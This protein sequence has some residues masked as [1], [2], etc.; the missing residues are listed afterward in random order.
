MSHGPLE[1]WP[2]THRLKY[3]SLEPLEPLHTAFSMR[4]A[5]SLQF[6]H[7]LPVMQTLARCLPSHVL[8]GDVGSAMIRTPAMFHRGTPNVGNVVR[9]QVT[10]VIK[11]R[12]GSRRAKCE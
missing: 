8:V 4:L 5:G 3:R 10:I 2:Q 7:C 11:A 6:N 12:G 1:W 9:P